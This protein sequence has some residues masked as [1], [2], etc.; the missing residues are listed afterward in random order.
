M[1]TN[2]IKYRTAG[3]NAQL[4]IRQLPQDDHNL[5]ISFADNGQGI[6]LEKHGDKIFGMYKTFHKHEDARGVGLYI[7]K[8]QVES[9]GGKIWVEST[10]Q[11]GSTFYIMMPHEPVAN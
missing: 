1:I 9:M 10:P 3:Q 11:V 4:T 5:L 2:A 7:T 8:N 6:D